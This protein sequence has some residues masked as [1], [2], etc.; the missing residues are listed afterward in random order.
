MMLASSTATSVAVSMYIDNTTSRVYALEGETVRLECVQT[1]EDCAS[2][3]WY[4]SEPDDPNNAILLSNTFR[5][6]IINRDN[7]VR[8]FED[9]SLEIYNV[10]V[11]RT[12]YYLCITVPSPG[13]NQGHLN[14]WNN[15]LIVEPIKTTTNS[16]PKYQCTFNGIIHYVTSSIEGPATLQFRGE[17]DN[18]TAMIWG[19]FVTVTTNKG[20]AVRMKYVRLQFP[21]SNLNIT[22]GRYSGN[23][24][25]DLIINDPKSSDS[26]LYWYLAKYDDLYDKC[27]TGFVFLNLSTP[28]TSSENTSS[29]DTYVTDVTDIQ[30]TSSR[31]AYETDIQITPSR[32][33]YETDIPITSSGDMI[34][35]LPT[36][37]DIVI[38]TSISVTA[39]IILIVVVCGG[40]Y[41]YCVK[42]APTQQQRHYYDMITLTDGNLPAHTQQD[43]PV[44][45][46]HTYMSGDFVFVG[47]KDIITHTYMSQGDLVDHAPAH[48]YMSQGDL[49]DHAPAHTYMSQGDLVD[50]KDIITHTYMTQGDPVV[51]D[52]TQQDDLGDHA[53]A[54][55]YMPQGDLVDEKDIITHTYMTQDG[56]G[57]FN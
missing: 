14:L 24:N 25:Y 36:P 35:T 51:E 23:S 33:A 21:P 28:V 52:S 49:V 3:Y 11:N 17:H 27:S 48:T 22:I 26:K 57:N 9:Y 12:G 34:P 13:P 7:D 5:G 19:D 41:W 10:G 16:D 32:D 45:P 43:D 2:V 8:L 20:C 47:E 15:S 56:D 39:G 1:V 46:A 31:D 37:P 30:I 55:T 42:K 29:E 53:P 50:E 44:D 40:I 38:V 6:L 4:Y 18:I 54:H